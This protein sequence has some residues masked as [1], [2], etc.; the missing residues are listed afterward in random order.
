MRRNIFEAL[1]GP[2]GA[3]VDDGELWR[4]APPG[5]Q[6]TA[7]VS[8]LKPSD[9]YSL[10]SD[11]S[12]RAPAGALVKERPGSRIGSGIK[13]LLR[14][15]RGLLRR[16]K[17]GRKKKEKRT[18]EKEKENSAAQDKPDKPVKAKNE[19]RGGGKLLKGSMEL[20]VSDKS[21]YSYQND[22]VLTKP[23]MESLG[24][25]KKKRDCERAASPIRKV[26]LRLRSYINVS[27]S[28]ASY[29]S[30]VAETFP[31]FLAAQAALVPL[32]GP[33]KT[34]P[35]G[36][37]TLSSPWDL[38]DLDLLESYLKVLKYPENLLVN[39]KYP[40]RRCSSGNCNATV[41]LSNNLLFRSS[42][43]PWRVTEEMKVENENGI[44]YTRGW[45][46][47][48]EGAVRQPIIWFFPGIQK[49]KVRLFIFSSSIF[50]VSLSALLN[51]ASKKGT[52][53]STSHHSL[54]LS[55]SLSLS[56]ALLQ[57]FLPRTLNLSDASYSMAWKERR[58]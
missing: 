35:D 24:E 54:S 53:Q 19:K 37:V 50:F 51:R 25:K 4:K 58:P 22:T 21:R 45:T 1:R 26:H 10:E 49:P 44:I 40:T 42:F 20:P 16:L 31:D 17:I 6:D 48:K 8:S 52:K 2:T 3:Q 34:L 38:E 57:S 32:G 43:Q 41:A 12:T 46:M 47:D 30:L 29:A 9:T 18:K 33:P 23:Q 56:F 15:I 14:A 55:L 27:A 39:I 13:R 36:Q 7:T 5:D 28:P 11:S